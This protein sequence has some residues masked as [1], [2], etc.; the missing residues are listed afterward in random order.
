MRVLFHKQK[1][2]KQNITIQKQ[3]GHEQTRK[4]NGGAMKTHERGADTI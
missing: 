3:F 2:H 1:T 4:S